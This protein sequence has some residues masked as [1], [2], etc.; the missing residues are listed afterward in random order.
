LMDSSKR[1][2]Q[3]EKTLSC[4]DYSNPSIK[5]RTNPKPTFS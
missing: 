4:S 5:K 1:N 2:C 3:R